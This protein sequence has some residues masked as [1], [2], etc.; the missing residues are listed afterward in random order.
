YRPGI[1]LVKIT[2]DPKVYAVDSHGTLRWISSQAAASAIYGGDWNTKID[3]VPD[4]FFVNYRIGTDINS[5][6]DFNPQSVASRN[7]TIN[8]DLGISASSGALR[9]NTSTTAPGGS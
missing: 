3:D 5:A 7:A 8:V 1:R 9:S 6:A 4:A 2:T